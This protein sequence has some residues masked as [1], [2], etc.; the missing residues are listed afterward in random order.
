VISSLDLRRR[1]LTGPGILKPPLLLWGVVL[2]LH[3]HGFSSVPGVLFSN[4]ALC[5]FFVLVVPTARL[6]RASV[7][8]RIWLCPAPG[9]RLPDPQEVQNALT[10]F[11]STHPLRF[12][13]RE[14]HQGVF[15]TAAS[16][17][18]IARLMLTRGRCSLGQVSLLLFPSF[19]ASLVAW[20]ARTS[21]EEATD[22]TPM[23]PEIRTPDPA[24]VPL[25]AICLLGR[26]PRTKP[27]SPPWCSPPLLLTAH[28][29]QE[30]TGI[31]SVTV[32]RPR[33]RP[34]S[35]HPGF[36][37]ILA[38]KALQLGGCL[39]LGLHPANHAWDPLALTN[40]QTP[41]CRP[42]RRANVASPAR[43]PVRF[44]MAHL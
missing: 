30:G 33:L 25:G 40:P 44:L 22:V 24:P 19:S 36:P 39:L 26:G 11:F 17:G 31:I 42:A 6:A 27:T 18:N 7:D 4:L 3:E 13:V 10:F 38:F 5:D 32:F 43:I 20:G 28:S 12:Q 9:S 14:V 1:R 41:L 2:R 29:P 37:E 8:A 15:E 16:N 23:S 34:P 35:N 21:G